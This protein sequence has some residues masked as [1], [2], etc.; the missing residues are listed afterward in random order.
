MSMHPLLLQVSLIGF[1]NSYHIHPIQSY[2][3]AM[4]L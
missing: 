3:I 4:W 1:D 2:E